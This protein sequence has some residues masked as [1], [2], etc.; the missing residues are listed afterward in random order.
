MFTSFSAMNDVILSGT[1]AKV[2]KA[3]EYDS[4]KTANI[5]AKRSTA[6][7]EQGSDN[8]SSTFII[9]N[10]QYTIGI[11]EYGR[12]PINSKNM[13]AKDLFIQLIP[14]LKKYGVL[15]KKIMF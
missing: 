2:G 8:I 4:C 15:E 12:I 7:S 5:F 3:L 11:M 1:A 6:E 10:Q 9:S 13:A 14:I